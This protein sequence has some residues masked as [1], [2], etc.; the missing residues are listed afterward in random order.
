M[1]PKVL[2]HVSVSAD[3]RIDGGMHDLA[4]YYALAGSWKEDATLAGSDTIAYWDDKVSLE[5]ESAFVEPEFDPKDDRA[6]LAVIDSKGKVRSWHAA[7][8]SGY[9]SR[10]V[11]L[12]TSSTPKEYLEYLK[13]RHIDIM[14]AGKDRVDLKKALEALNRRYGVRRVRVESG[15]VLNGL[16]LRAGLVDEVSMVINPELVGGKS[17]KYFFMAEDL[18]GPEGALKLR[19]VGVKELKKGTVHLRYKLRR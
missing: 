5:D 11:A 1:L 16:L 8:A 18:K 12:C 4:T 10:F 19:L 9:W 7:R 3:G 15:G 13:K 17:P 2:V 14:I 6:I